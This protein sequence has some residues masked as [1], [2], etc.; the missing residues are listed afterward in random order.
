MMKLV[1][2]PPASLA[3]CSEILTRAGFRC[4]KDPNHSHGLIAIR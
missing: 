4:E 3:G 1:V 2:H